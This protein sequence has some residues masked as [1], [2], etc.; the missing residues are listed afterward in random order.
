MKGM[1]KPTPNLNSIKNST[2]F[3]VLVSEMHYDS[4]CPIQVNFI[5]KTSIQ[6]LDTYKALSFDNIDGGVW[7]QGWKIEVDEKD[8]NRQNKLKVSKQF[9]NSKLVS[10]AQND[11]LN[12]V[13]NVLYSDIFL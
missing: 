2:V 6:M 12:F 4:S 10:I 7:K 11:S 5:P 3:S 1:T 8:W 9:R 13:Q